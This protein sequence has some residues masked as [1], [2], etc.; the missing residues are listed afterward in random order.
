MHI[1][2]LAGILPPLLLASSTSNNPSSGPGPMLSVPKTSNSATGTPRILCLHGAYQSASTFYNK[3]AGA[4]RKLSRAFELDFLDGPVEI[5][6]EQVDDATEGDEGGRYIPRAWWRRDNDGRH[7]ITR[8]TFDYVCE[9]THGRHYDALI[10]FSQGGTLATAL[11]LSGTVPGV[12]VV[13]TAGAPLVDEAFIVAAD[14]AASNYKSDNSAVD[15]LAMPK[16]HLAGERDDLV[17]VELT[18]ALCERGGGGEMVLHEQGHLF[19]TRAAIVNR[20]ID[21]LSKAL[22]DEESKKI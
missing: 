13:I 20:V 5:D 1:P 14:I 2:S 21:F 11:A 7:V 10:G 16:L 15:R 12:K 19:P 9:K 3:I 17:D 4:R 22:Q 18:R 6:Q 8:E